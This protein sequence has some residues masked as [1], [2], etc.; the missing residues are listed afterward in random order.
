MSNQA[1]RAPE[2]D[3]RGSPT[4]L[5]IDGQLIQMKM[6]MRFPRISVFE[7][8]MSF[9]ECELLMDLAAP[10]LIRSRTISEDGKG[11]VEHDVR[12]SKGAGFTRG[13]NDFITMLDARAA[14]LLNWPINKAEPY[15]VMKYEVG[16]EYKAHFDYFM[17]RALDSVAP[18]GGQRVATLI[19]YLNTPKQGGGTLFPEIGLEVIPSAGSAVFFNYPNLFYAKNTLHAG[20]P[21]IEGEKWIATKWL[22]EAPL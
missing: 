12:T 6:H 21:V 15:Q 8:F 7:N 2:V 18:V 20:L 5:N 3:L 13:E 19:I 1:F 9:E 16:Q 17:T 22:R 11:F 14:R 10:K 4:H